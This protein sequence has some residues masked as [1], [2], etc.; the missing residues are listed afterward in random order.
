MGQTIGKS[1]IGELEICE[2]TG[3]KSLDEI[4]QLRYKEQCKF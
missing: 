2:M 3:C 1:E 4:Q